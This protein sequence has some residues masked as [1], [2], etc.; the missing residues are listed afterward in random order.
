MN[1]QNVPSDTGTYN[2][3]CYTNATTLYNICRLKSFISKKANM[4]TG[5]TALIMKQVYTKC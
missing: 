4:A 5:F 1:G 2:V 3:G